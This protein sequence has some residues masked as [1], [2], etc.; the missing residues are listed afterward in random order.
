[1]GTPSL[2]SPLPLALALLRGWLLTELMYTVAL[3]SHPGWAHLHFLG[4]PSLYV[5][6]AGSHRGMDPVADLEGGS[7]AAHTQH[8]YLLAHLIGMRWSQACHYPTFSWVHLWV[9]P[10]PHGV[11]AHSYTP[12]LY[13]CCVIKNL[14]F[15]S[16]SYQ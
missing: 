13:I 5:S 3:S 7:D 10:H 16:G 1:M 12:P 4:F 9:L 6:S 8:C 14:P 2:P 11:P 15:I